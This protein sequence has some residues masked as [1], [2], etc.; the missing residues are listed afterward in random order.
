MCL[1]H[2]INKIKGKIHMVISSGAEKTFDKSQ[3]LYDRS[4]GESTTRVTIPPHNQTYR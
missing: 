2:D 4:P 1:K 3:R